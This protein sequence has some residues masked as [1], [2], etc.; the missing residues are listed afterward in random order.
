M[1]NQSEKK[2]YQKPTAVVILLIFF[3][4]VGL[5]LM[6]KYDLWNKTSR[7]IISIIFGLAIISNV[8]NNN[9]N[10]TPTTSVKE[11]EPCEDMESYNQGLSEGRL[12]RG[13]L[14]D[15][16]TYYPYAGWADNYDCWCKGFMEGRK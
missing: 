14:P 15:C 1:E 2:W 5:Y 7:V 3:F 9:N 11:Y 4:P 8:G 12:Q 16:E 10:I 13:G 6:W